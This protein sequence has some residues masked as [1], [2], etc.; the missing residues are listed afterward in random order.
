MIWPPGTVEV[1][2]LGRRGVDVVALPVDLVR[3]VAEDGVE[4]VE[5]DGDEVGVGDPGAVEAVAGLALLV[6][7]NPGERDLVD[8]GVAAGGDERGHAADRVRA[9]GVAG[10]DEQLR[11]GAHERHGHRHLRPVG[12]HRARL[13]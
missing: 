12:Q 2:Q 9:A 4:A 1:D 13:S 10:L 6:L 11:V 8:F 5:R 7:A 3:P